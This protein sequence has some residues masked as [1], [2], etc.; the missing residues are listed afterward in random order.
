MVRECGLFDLK[1]LYILLI[2]IL[3]ISMGP[4]FL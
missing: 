2:Y 3:S 1:R 4:S